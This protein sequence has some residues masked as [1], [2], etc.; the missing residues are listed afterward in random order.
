[1]TTEADPYRYRIRALDRAL[2][3][4]QTLN[5]YNGLNASELS[6][7]VGLPRPTVLRFLSTLTECGY[8]RRSGSDDRYRVSQGVRN[9]SEGYREEP[10]LTNIVRPYLIE[11]QQS[12]I[13]PLAFLR[14]QKE[15]LCI[16]V[17]TDNMSPMVERRDSVGA[18]VPFFTS[19]SGYLLIAMMEADD[20][21]RLTETLLE[22][23]QENLALFDL[24]PTSVRACIEE[25]AQNGFAVIDI[26]KHTAISVPV[27]VD[28]V[29]FAGLTI[30][31]KGLRTW[32]TKHVAEFVEKLSVAAQKIG[33]KIESCKSNNKMHML[34]LLKDLEEQ[35]AL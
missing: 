32:E 28:G 10:W 30:R 5:Q 19:A 18:E 23:E 17:V 20:R 4:L 3:I 21:E 26:K 7:I 35:P 8:V 2:G 27:Y 12:F 29:C 15:R 1:M 6:R 13:W 24:T 9:L 22:K 25:T 11:M 16:D 34:S 31:V 33:A 14:L